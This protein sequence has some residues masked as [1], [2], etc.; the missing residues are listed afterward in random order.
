MANRLEVI[1]VSKKHNFLRNIRLPM[2]II[3][4]LAAFLV[5][6]TTSTIVL[7][8]NSTRRTFVRFHLTKV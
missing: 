6:A 8:V 3:Y 5:T 4:V 1:L 2:I 7:F